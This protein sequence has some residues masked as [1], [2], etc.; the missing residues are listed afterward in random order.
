MYK[1]EPNHHQQLVAKGFPSELANKALGAGLNW[2]AIVQL[3]ITYGVPIAIQIIE[4][5]LGGNPV[6]VTP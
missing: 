5:L 6:P 3:I 1:I 4:S 2:Q